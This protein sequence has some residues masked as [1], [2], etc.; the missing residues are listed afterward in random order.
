MNMDSPTNVITSVTTEESTA[1]PFAAFSSLM[2][3]PAR[4]VSKGINMNRTGTMLYY[5]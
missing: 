4:P 1:Q 2:K 5:K 3:K